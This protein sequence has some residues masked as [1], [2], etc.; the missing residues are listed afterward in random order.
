MDEQPKSSMV[1]VVV[2]AII[3]LMLAAPCALWIKDKIERKVAADVSVAQS[4]K[5]ILEISKPLD[6]VKISR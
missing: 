4:L 3:F 1:E 6:K 5:A 2:C